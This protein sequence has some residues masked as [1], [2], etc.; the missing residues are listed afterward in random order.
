[1]SKNSPLQVN[2]LTL[3]ESC[4]RWEANR[5]TNDSKYGPSAIELWSRWNSLA[6]ITEIGLTN[7]VLVVRVPRITNHIMS[8]QGML[9]LSLS[10]K[11]Y[12]DRISTNDKQAITIP[13][14]NVWKLSALWAM[15]G[16]ICNILTKHLSIV[17]PFLW[18]VY[19]IWTSSW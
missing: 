6:T 18:A 4:W 1:M 8:C 13:L 17:G 15:V 3:L 16:L 5:A 12:L 10:N 2:R 7:S 19:T 9:Y 14:G 11:N